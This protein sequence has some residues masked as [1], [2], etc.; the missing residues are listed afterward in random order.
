MVVAVPWA[1]VSLDGA[2]V[3]TVPLRRLALAPG[4]HVVR[5]AHPDYQPVQR[6]VTVRAGEALN[7]T[8][9]LPEEGVR[10]GK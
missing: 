5:F 7:L 8:V 3:K 9:D 4:Q 6:T 1:D 10:N 2:P